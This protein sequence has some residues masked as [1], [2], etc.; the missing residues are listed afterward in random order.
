M[1]PGAE[2]SFI[3]NEAFSAISCMSVH[4]SQLIKIGLDNSFY[5]IDW[6]VTPDGSLWQTLVLF[7]GSLIAEEMPELTLDPALCVTFINDL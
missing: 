5:Y 7:W 4:K 1:G 3:S 2:C 6:K